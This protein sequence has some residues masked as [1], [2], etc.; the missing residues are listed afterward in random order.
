MPQAVAALPPPMPPQAMTQGAAASFQAALGSA[1]TAM[2]TRTAAPDTASNVSCQLTVSTRA[3]TCSDPR[4][5]NWI[6]ATLVWE[7]LPPPEVF[8]QPP[9][10]ALNLGTLSNGQITVS[11]LL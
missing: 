9:S 10:V 5:R 1:L 6:A 11:T 4:W 2:L 8:G 3:L 7:Q